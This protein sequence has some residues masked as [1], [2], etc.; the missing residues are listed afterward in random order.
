MRIIRIL[1]ATLFFTICLST[2]NGQTQ[3]TRSVVSMEEAVNRALKQNNQVKASQ[4]AVLQA[5][6]NKKNAWTRLFPR[7]SFNSAYTWIDDS[8]LALRDFSRYFQDPNLPFNIPQTV[9]Q[10]AFY[11]S[12]ILTMPIYDPFLI[13]GLSIARSSESMASSLSES[14][15]RTIIFQVIRTYL[16]ILKRKEILALQQEYLELSGLNYEKAERLYE[17]GRY[18]MTDA[19]RWKVDHQ[20]Q[21]SIVTSSES[22]LRSGRIVLSRLLNGKQGEFFDV[23]DRISPPLLA[24][25]DNL[26]NLSDLDLLAMIQIDDAAL[27]QANAA[28]AAAK[29]GEEISETSYRN[30]YNAYLPVINLTYSYAWRENSTLALDDYSPKTLMVN[31]SVPVF[32]SFQNYTRLKAS[33]YEYKKTQE[34]FYNHM[35]DIRFVLTQTVNKLVNLK[36]Q[37]ELSKTSIEFNQRNYTVIEQQKEKGL[38][39]NIDFID[40][41]L[42]LQNAQLTDIS[43]YYDFIGGMVE[44][45]YLLGRLDK[46]IIQ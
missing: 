32:T 13:N 46:I 39:S 19:L 42:N 43:N 16:D 38:V 5:N 12:F 40:A 21:K 11:S 6:W 27:M 18:S 26:L 33:Y 1:V 15:R 35:Q 7:I 37:K 44:L 3:I 8:T 9:F 25:S 29:R 30:S 34:E 28:L 36:M 31:L 17:A 4:Y 24:E 22:E 23:E 2:T 41:K 10:N 45:Y 14:T 20:Q